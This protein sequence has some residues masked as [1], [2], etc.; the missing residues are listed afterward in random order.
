MR[1]RI[2]HI[3]FWVLYLLLIYLMME[4]RFSAAVAWQSASLLWLFHMVIAYTNTLVF[5][6]VLFQK[7]RYIQYI[8]SCFVLLAIVVFAHQALVE[9]FIR[10][11]MEI[12]RPFADAPRPFPG[13][14]F[15]KS[16]GALIFFRFSPNTL[17]TVIIL[18]L[19]SLFKLAY[20]KEREASELKSEGLSSELKFLKSQ[21]NPHFLFNAMNNLYSLAQSKS[22]KTGEMILKLSDMLRYNLYETGHDKVKISEEVKYIFN[23]VEF[24]KVRMERPENVKMKVNLF[25]DHLISPMLLIPF[26]ENAFK[27]SKIENDPVANITILIES[28]E[29]DIFFTISNTIPVT[30]H[31]KDD[32]GGIGI[33]NVRRRLEILYKDAHKLDIVK[34]PDSFKVHLRIFSKK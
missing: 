18:L 24:H 20:E 27:H 4:V 26:I 13:K 23:Y 7:K 6:P 3:I 12:Q 16:P 2:F 21:I 31:Q 34:N 22:G 5:I 11:Q 33:K 32:T 28:S 9:E 14:G 29:T 10:P 25:H 15:R 1:T 19:S 30:E 8:V 17:L